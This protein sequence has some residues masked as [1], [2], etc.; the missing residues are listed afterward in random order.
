MPPE[1]TTYDLDAGAM[2]Y[3]PRG[4]WHETRSDE[5]SISIHIHLSEYTWADALLSVLRSRLLREEVWRSN[6]YE[7]WDPSRELDGVQSL[8]ASLRKNVDGMRV[9]DLVQ[10]E[11]ADV[12]EETPIVR[13]SATAVGVDQLLASER[14][15]VTFEVDDHGRSRSTTI[16]MT[17]Q[18]AFATLEVARSREALSARALALAI[19]GMRTQDALELLRLLQS[20]GF[21]R[22]A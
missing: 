2:L 16:E 19:P 20:I 13:R 8:L 9:E 4:Y 22:R 21:I 18:H 14:V 7:A 1:T 17:V 12:N 3:V 5:E 15:V 10:I 11:Q 6:A